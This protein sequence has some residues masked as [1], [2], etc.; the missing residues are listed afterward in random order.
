MGRDRETKRQDRGGSE[1]RERE[2][3]RERENVI[4]GDLK[5]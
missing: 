4:T 5:Y 3:E 2:R 1:E